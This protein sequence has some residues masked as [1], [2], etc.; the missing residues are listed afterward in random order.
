MLLP[1]SC[2][3]SA[4]LA[5]KFVVIYWK[6]LLNKVF[7]SKATKQQLMFRMTCGTNRAKQFWQKKTSIYLKQISLFFPLQELTLQLFHCP[8]VKKTHLF[9][10][11]F[12]IE[13]MSWIETFSF[14][15]KIFYQQQ[16]DKNSSHLSA[17]IFQKKSKKIF[18][19]K[20]K[21][22]LRGFWIKTSR[23]IWYSV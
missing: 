8:A 2:F 20:S 7:L 16:F 6:A 5:R 1:Q 12:L 22:N 3:T 11:S 10:I 18:E 9:L 13:R 19:K 4:I 17:V 14:N 21:K 15:N 23:C